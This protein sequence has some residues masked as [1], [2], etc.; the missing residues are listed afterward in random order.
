[1][2]VTDRAIQNCTEILR[3]VHFVQIYY[4]VY[5]IIDIFVYFIFGLSDTFMKIGGG[6]F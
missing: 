3:F 1:M 2:S 6:H 4:F 5:K